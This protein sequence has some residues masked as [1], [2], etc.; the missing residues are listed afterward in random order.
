MAGFSVQSLVLEEQCSSNSGEMVAHTLQERRVQR[1][2]PGCWRCLAG[3]NRFGV[4][5]LSNSG[6]ALLGLLSHTRPNTDQW[7]RNHGPGPHL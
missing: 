6:L 3:N 7:F 2:R 5:L 1:R 4:H